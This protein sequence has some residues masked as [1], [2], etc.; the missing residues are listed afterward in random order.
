[1]IEN[2]LNNL[3]LILGAVFVVFLL[4]TVFG[5]YLLAKSAIAPIASISEKLK[6]ISHENLDERVDTPDTNDEIK[7]LAV[8]FNSLLDRLNSA[9]KRERQ[10]I[11]DVAHELKTPLAIAGL[12]MAIITGEENPLSDADFAKKVNTQAKECDGCSWLCHWQGNMNQLER[13]LDQLRLLITITA[14]T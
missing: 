8:T 12:V 6:K 13:G 10:F 5:G 9:F 7:E 1:M 4:P 11:G 3:L 14:F 2:S